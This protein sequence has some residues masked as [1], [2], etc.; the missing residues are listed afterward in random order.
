MFHEIIASLFLITS[1]AERV[2][3][4]LEVE[5]HTPRFHHLDF[6]GNLLYTGTTSVKIYDF[7]RHTDLVNIDE[8]NPDSFTPEERES[9][10]LIFE[11]KP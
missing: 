8:I 9:A 2:V 5:H 1:S 7:G 4:L 6:V 10:S 3:I 11:K